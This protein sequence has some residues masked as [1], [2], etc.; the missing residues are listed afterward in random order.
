MIAWDP[1]A[2]HGLLDELNNREA[3]EI[4]GKT[5][6]RMDRGMCAGSFHKTWNLDL[7]SVVT[8]KI[9][10]ETIPS[11]V[12]H[13]DTPPSSASK[14]DPRRKRQASEADAEEGRK[15]QKKKKI[16]VVIHSSAERK[17]GNVQAGPSSST[18]LKRKDKQVHVRPEVPDTSKTSEVCRSCLEPSLWRC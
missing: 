5:S 3:I 2:Q 9:D 1:V 13:A 18:S 17:A 16:E 6:D 7:T 4:S 11:S 14:M 12:V 15:P 8:E 10:Q